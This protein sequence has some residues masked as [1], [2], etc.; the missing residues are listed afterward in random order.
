MSYSII[1]EKFFLK[2]S[3]GITPIILVGPNNVWEATFKGERRAREWA[4]YNID[5]FDKCED[6]LLK[7]FESYKCGYEHFKMNGQFVDDEG[8]IR[9]VKN[10]I[11]AARSVEE[12]VKATKN[13][14][15]CSILVKSDGKTLPD[16]EF[17]VLAS[18]TE[19][20]D[21]F[22][23]TVKDRIKEK[24]DNQT[25]YVNVKPLYAEKI[26]FERPEK[27][28]PV[29]LS[30][31]RGRYIIEIKKDCYSYNTDKSKALI[32]D[33]A[34]AAKS[35]VKACGF[36]EDDFKYISP[37][38]EKKK[39]FAIFCKKRNAFVSKVSSIHL[40]YTLN[41]EVSARKFASEN[42]AKKYIEKHLLKFFEREE[43]E[44]LCI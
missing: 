40:W 20:F 32:F 27:A 41:P 38:V 29:I 1:Y 16:T 31:M 28:G 23:K 14:L 25:I 44:I 6:E 42:E 22:V 9:F 4:I 24:S 2:S 15:S 8:L 19:E 5:L 35:I 33:S 37:K 43:F 18:T 26:T 30:N 36:Y 17:S 11:K 3:S 12:V 7:I 39:N 13:P 10:G 34:E 21:S